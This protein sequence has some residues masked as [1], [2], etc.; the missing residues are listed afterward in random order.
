MIDNKTK[1]RY[2]SQQKLSAI[3]NKTQESSRNKNCRLTPQSTH[4]A[5]TMTQTTQSAEE[6]TESK[7]L[8]LT[9]LQF[10]L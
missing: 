9:K 2:L 8:K 5:N 6:K 7:E 3:G 4:T 1:N 10:S